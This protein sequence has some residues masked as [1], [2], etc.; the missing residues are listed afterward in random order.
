MIT[1]ADPDLMNDSELAIMGKRLAQ[2]LS[3][4][5]QMKKD[6]KDATKELKEGIDDQQKEV[7]RL[8]N[9]IRTGQKEL[10]SPAANDFQAMKQAALNADE[11]IKAL[12]PDGKSAGAGANQ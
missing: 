12:R 6:M 1:E 11:S 10:F 9:L 3:D 4:L 7:E 5:R 8:A 2:A